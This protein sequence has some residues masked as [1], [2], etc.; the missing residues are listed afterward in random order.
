[1]AIHNG[2]SIE[3]LNRYDQ[4]LN[5]GMMDSPTDSPE[6]L[7]SNMCVE[8]KLTGKSKESMATVVK[9]ME[10]FGT[11]ARKKLYRNCDTIKVDN[12]IEEM[13]RKGF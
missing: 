10:D 11:Y 9:S 1:M 6:I 7:I 4:V 13:K 2:Y 8:K 5:T 12:F 3:K